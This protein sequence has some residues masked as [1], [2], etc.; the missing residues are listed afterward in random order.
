MIFHDIKPAKRK[1]KKRITMKR[2]GGIDILKLRSRKGAILHIQLARKKKSF[3]SSTLPKSLSFHFKRRKKKVS[4]PFRQFS[5]MLPPVNSSIMSI[6]YGIGTCFLI[7]EK[8]KIN[9]QYNINPRL[10]ML[11]KCIVTA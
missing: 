2:K 9:A 4:D 8:T 11:D 7:A 3:L 5:L 10:T 6:P 1:K